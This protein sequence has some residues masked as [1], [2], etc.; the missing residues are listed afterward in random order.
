MILGELLVARRK[1]FTRWGEVFPSSWLLVAPWRIGWNPRACSDPDMNGSRCDLEETHRGEWTGS[2][3]SA[4]DSD[5]QMF[6]EVYSSTMP[7]QPASP[8]DVVLPLGSEDGC[9]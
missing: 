9:V 1:T 6:S 3:E 5:F 4:G 7:P 2:R 8:R